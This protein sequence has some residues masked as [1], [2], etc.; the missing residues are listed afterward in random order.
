M[1]KIILM[2]V[3]MVMTLG[4]ATVS[5][6]EIFKSTTTTTEFITDISCEQCV[7]KIMNYLPTQKGIKDVEA[8]LRSK[9]V[10]ITY[11]N[12]K[13]SAAEIIKLFAKIDIKAKEY[14]PKTTTPNQPTTQQ[15]TTT[16]ASPSRTTVTTQQNQQQTTQQSKDKSR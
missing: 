14:D 2:V 10:T 15:K 4:S 3:A 1:K 6:A 11:K 7:K 13:T 16:T 9:I 12:S 8:D 5:A